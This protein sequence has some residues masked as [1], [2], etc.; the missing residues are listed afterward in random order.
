M[1]RSISYLKV[2]KLIK[3]DPAGNRIYKEKN[4]SKRK[5]IVDIVGDL[6]VILMELDPDNNDSIEKMYIYANSQILAQH[7][8]NDTDPRYFYLHDRLGSIRQQPGSCSSK[9]ELDHSL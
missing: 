8:G 6:P 3:Y 1:I 9:G 5:Y 2:N 4:N 7:D